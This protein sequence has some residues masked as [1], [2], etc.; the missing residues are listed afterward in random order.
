[1]ADLLE[2]LLRRHR[3]TPINFWEM[4]KNGVAKFVKPLFVG[5]HGKDVAID[6]HSLLADDAHDQAVLPE[7][8]YEAQLELRLG[9]RPAWVRATRR[10]WA[11]L[12]AQPL[13][14]YGVPVRPD[15]AVHE[16]SFPLTALLDDLQGLL[17]KQDQGWAV[18]LKIEAPPR[19]DHAPA[20]LCAPTDRA[21]PTVYLRQ[22]T[23]R[24]RP[25][26]G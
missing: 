10:E 18:P 4:Q 25:L 5:L 22:P 7:S 3:S 9:K 2:F 16:E 6:P 1:M 15:Q 20:G 24:P 12:R 23:S 14:F 13:P 26:N 17:G 11:Q 19:R 8:L 21:S